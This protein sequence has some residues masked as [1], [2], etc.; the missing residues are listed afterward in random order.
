MELT[1]EEIR[2]G[3]EILALFDGMNFYNDEPK[4]YPDGYFLMEDSEGD[5]MFVTND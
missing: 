2:E 4:S 1:P 3:N 5:G